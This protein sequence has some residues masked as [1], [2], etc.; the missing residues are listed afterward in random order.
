[1]F[2]GSKLEMDFLQV[3]C[4]DRMNSNDFK[5]KEGRFKLDRRQKFFMMRVVRH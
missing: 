4:S 1:L 2:I 3:I 5:L